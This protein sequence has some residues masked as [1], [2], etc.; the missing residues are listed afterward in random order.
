MSIE[1]IDLARSTC[2]H[3]DATRR[4][5]RDGVNIF[6]ISCFAK[7]LLAK[8][9]YREIKSPPTHTAYGA[10]AAVCG[11]SC[12][13]FNLAITFFA[14]NFLA[15][16]DMRKI[17]TPSRSPRRVELL[18]MHVDL[19]KP[20]FSMGIC[21]L[22]IANGCSCVGEWLIVPCDVIKACVR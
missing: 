6:I 18:C 2:M 8:K 9:G 17:F 14:N 15:K 12:R 19:T 10:G 16:Q 11:V 21:C 3:S 1:N 5:E 13:A 22:S 20:I 7:K 4:G